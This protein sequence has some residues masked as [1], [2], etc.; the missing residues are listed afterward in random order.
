MM[1]LMQMTRVL[2]MYTQTG[3]RYK[4]DTE[5]QDNAESPSGYHDYK[6]TVPAVEKT[7]FDVWMISYN[8]RL[9]RYSD[10]L[11]MYAEVLNENGKPGLALPYLNDV[12]ERARKTNPVD[13][14]RDQ[15]AYIPATTTNTL[16]DITETDQERLKEIIW[17]ERRC[18]LAM[19]GW[20]RD[21]LMRQKRFGTVMRAYATK[22][23]TSKGANFRDDRDYLFPIPQ[24]ERDKSNNILSQNPGF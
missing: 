18:E 22:Y 7:G 11:L 3:D 23:N 9:I 4:G 10:V 1:P 2:L 12:R 24:G 15:Q 14:R 21:D 5:A 16:P 6:M 8:I 19:E 13:P 20:R 17:K